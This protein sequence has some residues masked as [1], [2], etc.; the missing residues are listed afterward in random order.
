MDWRSFLA[1]GLLA[2]LAAGALGI[3]GCSET[4]TIRVINEQKADLRDAMNR[5]GGRASETHEETISAYELLRDYLRDEELSDRR[6]EKLEQRL[7]QVTLRYDS[8]RDQLEATEEAGDRLFALLEARAEENRTRKFRKELLEKIDARRD[9]LEGRL[10]A[11]GDVIETLGDSVQ[12]YDDIVGYLQVNQALE[13]VS[14]I[15]EDVQKVM[16]SGAK[17]DAQVQQYVREG[18]AVIESL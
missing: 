1:F 16:E 8:L 2:C 4:V 11:A 12:R 10:E 14:G 3:S 17:I 5:L 9:L 7:E 13:G 15:L 6:L 18:L